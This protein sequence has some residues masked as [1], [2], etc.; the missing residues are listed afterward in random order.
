MIDAVAIQ[1]GLG[2][3]Q[4]ASAHA[5]ATGAGVIVA[6]VDTGVDA[7]HPLLAGAL[8][9]GGFDFVGNDFDPDEE[10]NFTDDDGDGL[11]DEQFGHGT[12]IASL[13]RVVAP[14][15]LVLPVRVLD[16]EGFGTSSSVAAGIFWAVDAGAHVVNVSVDIPNA[17]DVVK[18][19]LEYA[20]DRGVVVVAA[21]GNRGRP[22]IDFPARLD[23]AIGVAAVDGFGARAPFSNAGEKVG[24]SA[25]GV[26]LLGAMPL[27]RNPAGTARWSGTSFAAPLV[28]GSAALVRQAFP[29]LDAEQV[30]ARLRA[31]ATPLAPA[32]GAG[33]VQPAAAVR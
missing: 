1:P 20:R 10:R 22:D 4:L 23:E 8:A 30:E 21:A 19:A 11:V 33:L 3:L 25:P 12:F 27:E 7:D 13:V 14:E 31:T 6:V 29:G 9:G 5:V 24:L 15:A 18:A 2:G 26:G 17:P 32:L 16:D 28:A